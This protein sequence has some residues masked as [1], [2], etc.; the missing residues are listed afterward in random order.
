MR[1][2]SQ[3]LE[4]KCKDFWVCSTESYSCFKFLHV[5]SLALSYV[6]YF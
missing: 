2:G 6:K 1:L 5:C 4:S 3:G